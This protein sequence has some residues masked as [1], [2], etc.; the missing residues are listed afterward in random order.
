MYKYLIK[1]EGHTLTGFDDKE[2]AKNFAIQHN[3]LVVENSVKEN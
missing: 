2:E 3:A 1:K